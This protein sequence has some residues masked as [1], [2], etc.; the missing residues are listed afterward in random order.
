MAS[1][2]QSHGVIAGARLGWDNATLIDRKDL[3]GE[4]AV[5]RIAS[6]APL[7]EFLAGQYTTVGLPADASRIKGADPDESD[8]DRGGNKDD[9]RKLIV[10]DYSIASSSKARDYVELYVTLVRSGALTPRLW[11]L[12]PGGRLWLGSKAKGLFTL[13][14]VGPDRDIVLIGTG[15]GLAPYISMIHDYHQ[16]HTG[17]RFVVIHGARH[18]RDL[19]YREELEA[20]QRECRTMDYVPTVSRPEEDSQ[21]SG[22]IGRVQSVVSD[23]TLAKALGGAISTDTTHVF[24]SGNPEM[25][26]DMVRVCTGQGFRLHIARSPGNLHVERYW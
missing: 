12:Q 7:F 23:G 21:W 10:R 24:V 3:T 13:D 22:H 20:L 15:T 2:S 9:R 1:P 25:V 16:C 5:F 8:N 6:D 19:G 26:E 11:G 14:G 18:E 4:S 17:R